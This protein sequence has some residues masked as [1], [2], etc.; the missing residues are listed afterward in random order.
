MEWMVCAR[1]KER[2]RQRRRGKGYVVELAAMRVCVEA[3]RRMSRT[4]LL[5]FLK[6]KPLAHGRNSELL[7][8]QCR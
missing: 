1:E 2:A 5:P 8:R 6:L 4:C 7:G 3:H